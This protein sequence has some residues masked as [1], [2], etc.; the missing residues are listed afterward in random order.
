[1][2]RK[3]KRSSWR[4]YCYSIDRSKEA[5][6]LRKI[7]S[8]ESNPPSY[9]K[10]SDESWTESSQEIAT[11]LMNSHFPDSSENTNDIYDSFTGNQHSSPDIVETIVTV[12]GIK[13]AVNTFQAFKSPGPDGIF[14]AL[15]QQSLELIMPWLITLFKASLELGYIPT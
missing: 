12:E 4:S 9:L 11:F 3:S 1:M 14:P 2:I 15:I 6:R 5:L 7:L 10:R 13:W 8:K